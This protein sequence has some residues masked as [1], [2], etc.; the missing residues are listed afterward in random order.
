MGGDSCGLLDA[1]GV[2]IEF[3]ST[4]QPD[5]TAP[6][7]GRLGPG[8]HFTVFS[9]IIQA[10]LPLLSVLW[11]P[12]PL[13]PHLGNSSTYGHNMHGHTPLHFSNFG[14]SFSGSVA[15]S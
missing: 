1:R 12:P 14:V 6:S 2:T 15:E 13:H 11:R 3:Y 7:T 4:L 5:A 10:R 9:S 8:L